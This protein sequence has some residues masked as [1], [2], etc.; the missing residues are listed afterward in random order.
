MKTRITTLFL[1]IGG[2][3]LTNGWDT[4]LRKKTAE[5]F[6]IDPEVV[7]GRHHLTY[8]VYEAGKMSIHDY[9]KSIIFFEPRPFTEKDVIK[10]I[11]EQATPLEETITLIKKLKAVYNLRI[12][13][14][15][16]EGRDIAADRIERFN[17]KEF[18]DFF[19]VSAFV[20]FRK[21]DLDIFHLALD[22]AQ[23]KPSE[24]AYV[25]D[26]MLHVEAATSLGIHG[27][28]HENADTTRAKLAQL[29]LAL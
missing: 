6:G 13:V 28:L 18:V 12:A 1:D 9:L 27:I 3:L 7:T 2:V 16:N 4:A 22:V 29:G 17:L 23:V 19:I 25:E 26:R 5:H 14:V 15:S 11:L 24:V 20:H 21:P 10:Y 8:D